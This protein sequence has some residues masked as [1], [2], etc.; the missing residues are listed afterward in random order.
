MINEDW[1]DQRFNAI[2]RGRAPLAG[3]EPGGESVLTSRKQK[4]S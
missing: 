3:Q 1:C 4:T 2:R